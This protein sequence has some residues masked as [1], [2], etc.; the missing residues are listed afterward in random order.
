MVP[1]EGVQVSRGMTTYFPI[2]LLL[3]LLL[4]LLTIPEMCNRSFGM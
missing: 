1:P 2:L 3:L 4:L